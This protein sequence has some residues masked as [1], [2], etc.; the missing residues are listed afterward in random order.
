MCNFKVGRVSGS[1]RGIDHV[2]NTINLDGKN[3]FVDVTW[4]DP[5]GSKNYDDGY[6]TTY[7]YFNAPVEI[8]QTTHVWKRKYEFEQF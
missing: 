5:T 4:D 2:W 3:N 8:M 1:G 6:S 7:V